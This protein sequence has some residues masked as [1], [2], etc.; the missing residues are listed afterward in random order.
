MFDVAPGSSEETEQ[1]LF[2]ASVADANKRPSCDV[3][4]LRLNAGSKRPVQPQGSGSGALSA[5][6]WRRLPP[7][8][9]FETTGTIALSAALSVAT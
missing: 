2:V 4:V 6:M 5:R 9:L 1:H 3:A 8:V 7:R